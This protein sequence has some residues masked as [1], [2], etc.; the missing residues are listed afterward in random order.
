MTPELISAAGGLVSS[1]GNMIYDDYQQRQQR[2]WNEK[3]L[4]KQNAWSLEQWNRQNEFNTPS[5][6]KQRLIDAGMNP[7]YYGL[8][9]NSAGG[10][11][12]AQ[13]LGYERSTAP[14]G[15]QNFLG[16]YVNTKMKKEMQTAQIDN[17][18]ADT[19][20][21]QNETITETER[22]QNLIKERDEMQARIDKYISDKNVNEKTAAYI[23]KQ[24]DRYDEYINSVINRNEA[25]AA[26]DGEQ[27]HR[28]EELL[29]GEKELQRMSIA[30]FA[31][32]WKKWNAEINHMFAQDKL[33]AKQAKYYLVSLLTNGVYGSGLSAI[34]G[35]ILSYI[36]EDED[37]NPQEKEEVK[38][39]FGLTEDEDKGKK[40]KPKDNRDYSQYDGTG[41]TDSKDSKFNRTLREGY[42]F[43]KEH[44]N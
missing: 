15:L 29:P 28:I 40:E 36:N 44:A 43:Y 19:A 9:G 38:K 2:K 30:D 12:S 3:M 26:L 37:L 8:D 32:K 34:N 25:A 13:A 1:V 39:A 17:L 4:D 18:N 7:L 16:D 35:L 23:Q 14:S 21:K 27:R 20:K 24:F 22:R 41:W 5:A 42:Q 10:L 33:L 11:E 31:H 6:Q